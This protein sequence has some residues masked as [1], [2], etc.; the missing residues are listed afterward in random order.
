M[1]GIILVFD[2]QQHEEIMDHVFNSAPTI[3]TLRKHMKD[4][5]AKNAC[6]VSFE[7]GEQ[8]SEFDKV[9]GRWYHSGNGC[10][11]AAYKLADELDKAAR[12]SKP[13]FA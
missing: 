9:G 1:Q 6:R 10:M 2:E 7:F 3:A 12:N 5:E 13:S 11:K 4:A 8:F